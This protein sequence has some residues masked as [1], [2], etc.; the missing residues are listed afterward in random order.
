MGVYFM[1][2]IYLVLIAEFITAAGYDNITTATTAA[3]ISSSSAG[4]PTTPAS[5][6]PPPSVLATAA[7]SS[8]LVN[9]KPTEL[10]NQLQLNSSI[11][12]SQHNQL[13]ATAS[14]SNNTAISSSNSTNGKSILHLLIFNNLYST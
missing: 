6:T 14:R 7:S 11:T 12:I 3:S 9:A 2:I 1:G 4:T 10:F 13:N 8:S 5:L